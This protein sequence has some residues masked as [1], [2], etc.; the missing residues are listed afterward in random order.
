MELI[1]MVGKIASDKYITKDGASTPEPDLSELNSN[2]WSYYWD[3]EV[4]SAEIE[5]IQA[6]NKPNQVVDNQ[7]DLETVTG[8]T[9]ARILELKT[10][11]DKVI[12]KA[13]EDAVEEGKNITE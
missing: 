12:T 8:V 5:F 10:A 3:S 6:S 13:E 4:P 2:I 7:S 1:V 9:V 11:R